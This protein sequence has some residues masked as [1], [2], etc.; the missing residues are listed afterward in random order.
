MPIDRSRPPSL[1]VAIGFIVAL[2]K[3]VV[4]EAATNRDWAYCLMPEDGRLRS[5]PIVPP[6]QGCEKS[7]YLTIDAPVVGVGFGEIAL[8]GAGAGVKRQIDLNVTNVG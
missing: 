8:S 2:I 3:C 6:L 7:R 5:L 1:P 4:G